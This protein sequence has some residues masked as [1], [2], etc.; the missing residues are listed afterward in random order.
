MA[1]FSAKNARVQINGA[2]LFAM[3]WTITVKTDDLDVTNFETGGFGTY[4]GGI[5]DADITCDAVWDSVQDPFNNPPAIQP[6]V[7]LG[8]GQVG[9]GATVKFFLDFVNLGV[10]W[11]FAGILITSV[12]Q[13]TDVRGFIK[14]S[15]SAKNAGGQFLMPV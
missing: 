6:A 8:N 9:A 14:Y 1:F 13:D 3:R 12:T 4:F 10:F 2:N 5:I 7:I 15:F 11:S